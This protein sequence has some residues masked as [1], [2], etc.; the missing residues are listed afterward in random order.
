LV[1]LGKALVPAAL[2]TIAAAYAGH[3]R[4]LA[5]WDLASGMPAIF[6]LLASYFSLARPAIVRCLSEWCHASPRRAFLAAQALLIPYLL[7]SILLGCFTLDGLLRL[8]L[9]INLPLLALMSRRWKQGSGWMDGAA[10]LLIWLPLD[11][12]LLG[13]LWPWPPGQSGYYLFGV[14]GV[15]VAV[16]L[17]VVVRGMSEVGYTLSIRAKDL[18]LAAV[19]F[20]LFAPLAIGIGVL[21]GFLHP[22]HHLPPFLSSAGRIL[23]IYL[24]TG[25][26]EELLF[27]GLLQN[28]ILRWTSSPSLSLVLASL[29]FG[30]AHLNNGGHPDA[31]YFLLASLAGTAYGLVYRRSGT[32]AAPA[33]THTLVDSAWALFFRG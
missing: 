25:V 26:P 27:R 10:L 4:G 6:L 11:F 28:L 33:L 3:L 5:T 23:G 32:V 20:A 21:T 30:A 2:I 15:S 18:V 19:G 9:Y 17:F 1:D 8:F 24:V 14:L 31:R 16:F 22:S 7:Y 29:I 12:R 13:P